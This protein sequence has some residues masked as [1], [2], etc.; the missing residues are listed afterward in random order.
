LLPA[1]EIACDL[2]KDGENRM[3]YTV[4]LNPTIDKTM[5]LH[6]FF[7]GQTNRPYRVIEDGAGKA[8][9][10]A[11]VLKELGAD[12]ACFG[13]LPTDGQMIQNRLEDCSVPYEFLETDGRA[14]V[15]IKLFDDRKKTVTEI[16]ERG[17]RISDEKLRLIANKIRTAARSGD[18]IFLT[19]SLPDGCAPCF[20]ADMI[21]E[22][23]KRGV[24]CVLDAAGDALAA[25]IA[26]RP[27]FIKPNREEI[28]T[29]CS[30][31]E[32]DIGEIARAAKRLAE[33]GISY[34]MVSLGSEG[35]LIADRSEVLFAES[36]KTTVLSTVGAGDSMIAAA[37][38][39]VDKNMEAALKSGV[40][41]ASASV[42]QEGTKLMKRVDYDRL[43]G[44]VKVKK[45]L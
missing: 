20:Y 27:Y 40:A 18:W 16:N 9:N 34:V 2:E 4:Y 6:E 28:S 17:S 32:P 7:P 5:Y 41:A 11:V 31:H 12:V 23:H 44:A 22:L 26:A 15:N 33:E 10:V 42:M 35:A 36:L 29:L 1:A 39:Q 19:G 38:S 21:D 8:I 43:L 45:I 30:L 24:R 25:G 37:V 3:F 13:L 14:R